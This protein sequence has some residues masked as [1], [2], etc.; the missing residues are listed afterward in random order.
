[1]LVLKSLEVLRRI[2]S[3]TVRRARSLESKGSRKGGRE[4]QHS[5]LQASKVL[6]TLK[7]EAEKW[8][9]LVEGIEDIILCHL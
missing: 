9:K 3:R 1:M 5:M 7:E 4:K 2:Q 8:S 6:E